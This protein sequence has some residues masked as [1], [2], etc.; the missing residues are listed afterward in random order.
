MDSYQALYDVAKVLLLEDDDRK[1]AEI[2]FRKVVELT[3]ADRGFIVVREGESYDQKYDV[4]F[5]RSVVTNEERKFSRSLVRRVI[6]TGE[7]V[8]S[9]NLAGDPRFA[10]EKSVQALGHRSVIV[11]PLHAQ[12]E[13]FA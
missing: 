11:A 1:T 2:L 5:D 3:Q 4:R 6:E 12:G 7:I 8:H 9:A 10:N 13:V